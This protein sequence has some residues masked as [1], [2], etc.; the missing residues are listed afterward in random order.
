MNTSMQNEETTV[1]NTGSPD[2]NGASPATTAADEAPAA[3][4]EII[5]GAVFRETRLFAVACVQKNVK[6]E[7][8]RTHVRNNIVPSSVHIRLGYVGPDECSY[9]Y[10]ED[11]RATLQHATLQFV[12]DRLTRG[13]WKPAT[14]EPLALLR[15]APKDL[16]LSQQVTRDKHAEIIAKVI[17]LD[18]DIYDDEKREAAIDDIVAAK[19][20]SGRDPGRARVVVKRLVRRYLQSGCNKQGLAC[21]V[22]WR[23][24]AGKQRRVLTTGQIDRGLKKVRVGRP[25]KDG[26]RS[27]LVDEYHIEK[28]IKGAARYYHT[29]EGG[30]NWRH[31]WHMTIAT[32][33]YFD[34]DP[35]SGVSIEEQLKGVAPSDYPSFEQFKYWAKTEEAVV[36]RMI[37][38]RGL[39]KY[40]QQNRPL[41]QRTAQRVPGPGSSIRPV[42]TLSQCIE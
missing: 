32:S 5:E 23:P 1:P 21:R 33:H 37:A 17:D 29:K 27:F 3:L 8:E 6:K 18:E 25:R 28:I 24:R 11:P 12:R 19:K 7:K 10:V 22:Q 38:R 31:A 34:W 13:D 16:T 35:D 36:Q 40:N 20:E 2:L 39:R 26:H 42:V 4:P 9:I 14:K 15:F 41:N 30:G